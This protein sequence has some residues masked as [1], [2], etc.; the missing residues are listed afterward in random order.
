MHKMQVKGTKVN[1]LNQR[2][3]WFSSH[4]TQTQQLTRAR[5]SSVSAKWWARTHRA[6]EH[7]Q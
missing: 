7:L 4:N 2:V 6:T 5:I 3:G 1:A